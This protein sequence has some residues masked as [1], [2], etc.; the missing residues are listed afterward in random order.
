MN[1]NEYNE[2]EKAVFEYEK[3]RED[4]HYKRNL[5]FKLKPFFYFLVLGLALIYFLFIRN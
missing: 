3:A 2:L 4:F 1:I 5:V